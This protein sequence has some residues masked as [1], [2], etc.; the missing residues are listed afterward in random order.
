MVNTITTSD[1]EKI[2]D[3]NKEDK[4]Q[5]FKPNKKLPI[6]ID[7]S[8]DSW[9]APCRALSPILDELS[10]EYENKVEFYKVDVDEEY[11]LS[12]FFNIRSIPTILFVPVK[13]QP[14]SHTGAFPKNELKKFISKYFGE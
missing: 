9:C 7:F 3:Y 6:V 14:T 8:A 12:K 5:N 1:F 4:W 10:K 2:F 11:E 13:G